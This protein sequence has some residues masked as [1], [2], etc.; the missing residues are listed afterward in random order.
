MRTPQL[1][2]PVATLSGE[3]NSLIGKTTPF[4]PDVLASLYPSHDAYVK[5]FTDAA[6]QAV[7]R[8]VV[9]KADVPEMIDQAKATEVP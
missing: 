7:A 6:K 5:A 9:L 4:P 2:I 3:G 8:G 1:D